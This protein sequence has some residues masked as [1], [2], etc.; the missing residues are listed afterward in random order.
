[1]TSLPTETL[2]MLPQQATDSESVEPHLFVCEATKEQVGKVVPAVGQWFASMPLG[3]V[4]IS[5]GF[6]VSSIAGGE[7]FLKIWIV[8]CETPYMFSW[9]PETGTMAHMRHT[10]GDPSVFN[11]LAFR[12]VM[13]TK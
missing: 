13:P 4:N 3:N 12:H 10:P 11:S 1:M 7:G 9:T 8:P 5:G 6:R 2:V